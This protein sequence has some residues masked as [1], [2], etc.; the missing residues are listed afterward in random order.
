MTNVDRS[1]VPGR[2][3]DARRGGT[4]TFVSGGAAERVEWARLHE[5]ARAVAAALQA[6][7]VGPGAHV[8]LLALTSRALVTAI[9]ATW[10]AGAT[11]VVLPLPMRM[12]SL[13]EF[14]AQTRA[15]IAGADAALVA[16]GDELAA[17]LDRQEGDPPV[18]VLGQLLAE[19]AALGAGR[20][21][22]PA[23][24][25]ESLAVLQFTSGS[26]AEPKGVML[27]HRTILA[28]LD[29]ATEAAALDPESDVLVSWLPLYHDMGLIGL[30]TLAM[31]TGT[32]LV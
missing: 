12:G 7:G 18:V 19:A 26:T 3:A 16:I 14:V 8:A 27:P 20:F 5:D 22:P 9:Q 23:I 13:G 10:L 6:R 29:G 21:D 25:P 11:A 17:M 2:V 28:N 24:D 1:T 31:I 30:L 4:V 15:R 32:D